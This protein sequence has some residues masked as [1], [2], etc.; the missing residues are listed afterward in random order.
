[1]IV[2]GIDPGSHNTGWGVIEINGN[3]MQ[4]IDCG[5]ITT[6]R[7]AALSERLQVIFEDLAE[8]LERYQ[9]DRICMESIFHHKSAKS[10]LI[11]GH[12]RGVALLAARRYTETPIQEISPA[13]VKKAVTGSG[14]AD[15]R[16]V[17]EMICVLLGLPEKPAEDAADALAVAIAG[18][19]RLR[20][21]L[22]LGLNISRQ[23]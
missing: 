5:V 12:A 11:L 14:R 1:M 6:K 8:R 21:D 9:A 16:Q 18:S 13:E 20:M 17:Q 2:F 19:S 22:P 7:T 4:H 10:A 15:K 3:Q 23:T